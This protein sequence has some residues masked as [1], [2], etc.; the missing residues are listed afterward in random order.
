MK[1][2]G[3]I[4][5]E[6]DVE[7]FEVIKN[8]CQTI[9]IVDENGNLFVELKD[10]KVV[11]SWLDEWNDR[12]VEVIYDQPFDVKYASTLMK[13]YELSCNYLTL[14]EHIKYRKDGRLEDYQTVNKLKLEK[15]HK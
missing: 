2:S 4:Y 7:S 10:N 3:T 8:L 5:T 6:F 1:V 14:Y 13:L 12:H 11:K 15:K 9:G